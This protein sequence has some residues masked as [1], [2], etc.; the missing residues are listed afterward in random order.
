[1]PSLRQQ[2]HLFLI[3]GKYNMA[4]NTQDIKDNSI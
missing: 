2:K 3:K 1:M 4:L